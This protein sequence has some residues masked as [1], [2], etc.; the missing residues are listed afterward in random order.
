MNKKNVFSVTVRSIVKSDTV[1]FSRVVDERPG[2]DVNIIIS[3]LKMLFPGELFKISIEYY[4][5]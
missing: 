1:Y 3:A 5:A 4:G 2:V